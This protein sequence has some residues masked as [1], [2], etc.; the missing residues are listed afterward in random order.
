MTIFYSDVEP[1]SKYSAVTSHFS[2][3]N[4][5]N[6]NSTLWLSFL[7]SLTRVLPVVVTSINPALV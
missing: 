5:I 6:E 1:F 7:T 4:R 3:A 2:T